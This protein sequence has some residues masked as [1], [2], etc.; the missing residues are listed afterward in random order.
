MTQQHVS[1]A[2]KIPTV[3]LGIHVLILSLC[4]G[5]QRQKPLIPLVLL[6]ESIH[7]NL[8]RFLRFLDADNFL[9]TLLALPARITIK[10]RGFLFFFFFL[11]SWCSISAT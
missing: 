10:N 1:R 5:L 11:L 2:S 3:V 8:H 7:R 4:A 6:R 9:A